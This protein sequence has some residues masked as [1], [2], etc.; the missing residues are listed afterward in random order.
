MCGDADVTSFTFSEFI[1]FLKKANADSI[2]EYYK[3]EVLHVSCN[4]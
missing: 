2:D 1:S 3:E 4:L